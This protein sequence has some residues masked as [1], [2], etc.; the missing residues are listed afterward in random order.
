MPLYLLEFPSAAS[1]REALR[2]LF[3]D[4]SRRVSASGGQVIEMQVTADLQRAFVVAEHS[5]QAPLALGL[6]GSQAPLQEIAEVRLV[7]AAVADVK[8]ARRGATYLVEW[9]FPPDLTMD[10][11]LARKREKAPLYAN[12]PDVTFLRTYVREDMVKCLCFY[13][14][15]DEVAVRRARDVVSTPITRLHSLAAVRP[16]TADLFLD[17]GLQA[18]VHAF[19]ELRAAA[20]DAGQATIRKGIAFLSRQVLP[21]PPA[22]E[23]PNADLRRVA[24]AIA[25][26]AWSEMSTA[27]SLWCHRMVLAYVGQAPAGSSQLEEVRRRLLNVDWLGST[28]L[29]PA[30]AHYVSGAPLPLTWRREGGRIVLN[31]RVHWASNLFR[32]DFFQVVAAAPTETGAVIVAGIP[33][34]VAGPCVDAYPALLALQS[35]ASA[36]LTYRDVRLDP[37]WIITHDFRPFIREIRPSFLLLQSSFCWGLAQRA[38][39]EARTALQGVNESLRG[40]LD[41]LA[42]ESERLMALF[43][44]NLETRGAGTPERELVRLRLECARLATATTALE[45]KV[46]GGRGYVTTSPTARRLREAAFLPIQAPTAGQLRWEL[47]HSA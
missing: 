10:R 41:A 47:S 1:S 17:P 32:P 33:G 40:D 5:S 9:D 31:G 26:L 38:L 15:P 28:A 42:A 29:A 35:T 4:V 18:H 22:G 21:P 14:A 25:T 43:S 39:A 6:R 16:T 12:V 34:E 37:A 13:D 36:S 11:Y 7:G 30:L 23:R 3:E 2:P 19:F 46:V 27:F 44:H 24:G 8:A 45:A 20:V